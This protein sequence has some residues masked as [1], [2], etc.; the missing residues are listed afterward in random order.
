MFL[1]KESK[2]ANGASHE[3]VSS[4]IDNTLNN[5]RIIDNTLNIGHMDHLMIA[6]CYNK[7]ATMLTSISLYGQYCISNNLT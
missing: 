7:K 6:I 4:I 1:T 5:G 3:R 2:E